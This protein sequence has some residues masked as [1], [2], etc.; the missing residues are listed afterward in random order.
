MKEDLNSILKIAATMVLLA[1]LLSVVI[2]TVVIGRQTTTKYTEVLLEIKNDQSV[3]SLT[4][5]VGTKTTLPI[6]AM[7]NY[8]N[9]N[10]ENIESIEC[11]LCDECKVKG[12]QIPAM[13]LSSGLHVSGKVNLEIIKQING[14]FTIR[15]HKIH[16]TWESGNCTC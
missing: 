4:N 6:S 10:Y 14:L 12:K 9:L 5:M 7:Q 15:V 2:Y 11:L 3:S 13:F 1:A 8:I 16:C